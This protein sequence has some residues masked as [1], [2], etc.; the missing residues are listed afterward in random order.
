M[1]AAF[2]FQGFPMHGQHPPTERLDV[3]ELGGER[4]PVRGD[5]DLADALEHRPRTKLEAFFELCQR[6]ALARTLLYTEVPRHFVWH[7]D[8]S[9]RHWEQRLRGQGAIGRM[10]GV[11]PG[12]WACAYCNTRH[13]PLQGTGRPDRAGVRLCVCSHRGTATPAIMGVMT[14]I[15][16][17][18]IPCAALARSGPGAILLAH[19]PSSHPG[20]YMFPGPPKGSGR[21]GRHH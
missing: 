13:A 16:I 5:Q 9:N 15:S 10:Y 17:A 21:P 8:K 6:D 20:S 18:F 7:A 12:A 3:H 14:I 19:T 4:C 1:E 2:R 11:Q